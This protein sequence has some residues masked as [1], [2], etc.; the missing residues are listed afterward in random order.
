MA[1]TN[2]AA[3]ATSG[4]VVVNQYHLEGITRLCYSKDG[5]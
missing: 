5:Q 3:K 2:K 4:T 1:G